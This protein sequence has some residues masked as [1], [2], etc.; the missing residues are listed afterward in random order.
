MNETKKRIDDFS[1][2]IS[3]R[4]QSVQVRRKLWNVEVKLNDD[5]KEMFIEFDCFRFV[6]ANA[7]TTSQ[8]LTNPSRSFINGS[9]V[10]ELD[11]NGADTSELT[12]RVDQLEKEVKG[13]DAEI[14]HLN[15]RVKIKSKRNI[16]LR[17]F[18][19]LLVKIFGTDRFD[20]FKR[21][22]N[23][24]NRIG[25]SSTRKTSGIGFNFEFTTRFTFE[26]K[27]SCFF[28]SSRFSMIF[29]IRTWRN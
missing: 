27:R 8:P 17:S 7:W 4:D 10:G 15:E 5:D 2:K 21:S 29:R 13:R 28:S 18:D 14:R 22:S 12:T 19:F 1:M 16:F 24:T 20:I 11:V 25:K 6:L 26:S 9:F 23:I 3:G